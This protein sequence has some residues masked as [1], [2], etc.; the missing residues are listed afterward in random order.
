MKNITFHKFNSTKK[1]LT[2]PLNNLNINNLILL[3]FFFNIRF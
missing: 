3:K 1:S 2:K